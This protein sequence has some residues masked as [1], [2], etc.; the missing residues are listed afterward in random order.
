[1][2][3]YQLLQAFEF[4]ELFPEVNKMFPNARVHEDVFH[5]AF[6][7][8]C[9]MQPANSKKTIRYEIMND[10]DTD[11]MFCGADDACFNTTWEA[12]LG[13]E[14]KKGSGVDLNDTEIAAN[15]LLNLLFIAK[16]P[17]SFDKEFAK[18]RK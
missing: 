10:P 6:D 3:L 7:I 4:D 2:K 8:I 11:E 13:K 12:C 17:R 1:M 5:N 15:C 14:I 9:Q 16:H 18:L